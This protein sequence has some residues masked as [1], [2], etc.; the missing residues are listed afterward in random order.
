MDA[1]PAAPLSP[2]PAATFRDG[3]GDRHQIADRTRTELLEVL[4]L[5]TELTAVAAFEFALRERVSHLASFHHASFA[6]VRSVE[7]LKHPAALAVV[8]EATTGV[9]LS[10]L[11]AFAERT[12]VTFD[13][14]AALC[15]L[16]QLVPAVAML[17][18]NAPDVA[19]GA[20]AAERIVVTPSARIVVV[21]HVLGS[22]LAEVRL[23][24]DQYW[25]QLRV[26][27]PAGFAPPFN[28]RSD[29]TQLG[30]VA[31]GLILGRPLRND[32]PPS[33]LA[34]VV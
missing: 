11:L 14:D 31:L 29:V 4:S 34:E 28:H 23:S 8:S 33:Q 24:A 21:E 3:L 20:I 18:E 32:E 7:R 16:R 1:A 25:Q 26:A 30:A 17:H 12:N 10:E 5:R 13:I 27:L 19:H 9:R 2:P 15:L 6:R 22:A